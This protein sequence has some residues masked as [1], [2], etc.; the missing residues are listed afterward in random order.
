MQVKR[1]AIL[2]AVASSLTLGTVGAAFA[3]TSTPTPSA[4]FA[5]TLSDSQARVDHRI[6]IR[7]NIL[8]KEVQRLNSD[9]RLNANDKSLLLTEDQNAIN[10]LTA[11]ESKVN[12]ETTVE[13]VKA[14]ETQIVT[15]HV[16]DVVVPQNRLLI[17][18]DNMQSTAAKLG[19]TIADL[20]N[21]VNTL[22]S[23]GANVSAIQALLT[24]ASSKLQTINGELA[25]DQSALEA[26][27]PTSTG[28]DA[29]Y[30][31]VRK[32]VNTVR[33]E[34]SDI[35]SDFKQLKADA[36]ALRAAPTATPTP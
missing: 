4:Q 30:Q 22:S 5:E 3:A 14:D 25:N 15:Y 21:K 2:T 20:Q 32:D 17:A 26:I 34:F 24:D 8:N 6:T 29:T 23:Q 31:S 33:T 35:R 11:L 7:L 18:V 28:T 13:A 12:A 27:T 36:A 19:T 1:F 16:Y 9:S 10:G